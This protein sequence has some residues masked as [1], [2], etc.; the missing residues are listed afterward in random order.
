MFDVI[1]FGKGLSELRKNADLTQS[2]VADRLNLSRQA[3][4]KYERGESFPD[5]SV[6]VMI[7]ELFH[8]T[9]DELIGYGEPTEGETMIFNGAARG[10]KDIVA[11]NIDDI[12]N[13]AP[14]L[15]PSLLTKLSEKFSAQGM[16]ISSLLILADYLNAEKAAELMDNASFNI[17]SVD[18]LEKFIPFLTKDSIETIFEKVMNQEAD[19]HLLAPL[20]SYIDM[21][22]IE[23][24]VMEG[25]IPDEVLRFLRG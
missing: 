10:S 23:A 21:S 13:L 16:D 25:V 9:F 7:A 8:V 18:V 17:F 6:L 19:W 5:I 14:L 4:S 22:I 11:E 1:K 12:V 20:S 3:I 2:E 24:A 15:K